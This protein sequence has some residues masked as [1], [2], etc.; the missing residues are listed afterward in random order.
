M[1]FK[2]NYGRLN[3]S[4]FVER[5]IIDEVKHA[6]N[7]LKNPELAQV[8]VWLD[9][10]NPPTSAGLPEYK[11]TLNLRAGMDDIFV[12][13]KHRSLMQCI[14]DS[15]EALEKQLRRKQKKFLSKRNRTNLRE[16]LAS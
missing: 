10:E 12:Q 15:R 5:A 8:T 3:R 13:K 6:T 16:D 14:H 4:E 11:C 7:K 9:S 1:I 2:M